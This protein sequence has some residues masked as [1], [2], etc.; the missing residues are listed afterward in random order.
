[1]SKVSR[2]SK[3]AK[4]IAVILLIIMVTW[5]A[6][7][8]FSIKNESDVDVDTQENVA[9][10]NQE[11][12]QDGSEQ[13]DADKQD[14]QN[15]DTNQDSGSQAYQKTENANLGFEL[16]ASSVVL[17]EAS[18]GTIL[19]E[20]DMDKEVEPASITKIMTLLLI[21]EALDSGKIKLEDSVSVSEHASSM[22][23]SQVYLEPNETQTVKDLIKCISI[24]SANDACVTM[25]EYI[26]G[27]E[28]EFVA[29]MNA[30]AAELGMKH[31]KFVNSCGLDVDGH[32]SSALDVAIMS[33]ELI[34]K[35]PEISDYSTVWMDTITHVTKKGSSEFGL[36]NTNKL[37]R[38]YNGITGL[39]TGSTDKAKYC[40]SATANRNGMD[41]IAVVMGTPNHLDRFKEAAKLL[42]YA[43]AN[44][45]VYVD[46]NADL[47]IEPVKVMKGM[48]ETVDGKVNN[49]FSYLCLTDMS[50]DKITKEVTVTQEVEAPVLEGSKLG[51]VVYYYNGNKIGTVDIVASTPIEKAKYKDYL[52]KVVDKFFMKGDK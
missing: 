22:G 29:R 52:K 46:D 31:T 24:A 25:A 8:A 1:V 21:F 3:F 14:A 4:V 44:C 16:T 5:D 38:Y 6:V 10:A 34:T 17:M 50:Q 47:A 41:M 12:E 19:Y 45:S 9:Q 30:K 7:S 37:V 43:F 49:K 35:H 33:R 28:E 39:K 18:T 2:K 13:K 23:G 48:K 27:S 36:T 20:K 51:E 40:L 15:E 11:V 26:A 42:D 32:Y